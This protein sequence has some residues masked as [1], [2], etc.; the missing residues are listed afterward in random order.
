MRFFENNYKSDSSDED[1][2]ETENYFQKSDNLQNSTGDKRIAFL[3]KQY[4]KTGIDL[5]DR[6]K[7][8]EK[9]KEEKEVLYGFSSNQRVPKQTVLDLCQSQPEK[10]IL[11]KLDL[12]GVRNATCTPVNS[13]NGK[14]IKI[15]GRS[16]CGQAFNGDIVIVEADPLDEG[17]E[18]QVGRVIGIKLRRRYLDIEHPVFVCT[19]AE[20][21]GQLMIPL[22]KTVPKIHILNKRVTE[23]YPT[24]KNYKVE[25]YEYDEVQGY[26]RF[27]EFLEIKPEER[28]KY[29]YVVA[30]L[31]WDIHHHYPLGAVIGCF[32][33]KSGTGRLRALEMQHRIT[34]CYRQSTVTAVKS[35]LSNPPKKQPDSE[36]IKVYTIDHKN[37][38]VFDDGLSIENIS[39]GIAS[40]YKVGIHITDVSR[41]I[42]KDSP[43]DEEARERCNTCYLGKDANAYHML[44]EPLSTDLL[45]LRQGQPR[46][47][48]SIYTKLD[49][50]GRRSGDP[51]FSRSVI[52]PVKNLSYEEVQEIIMKG[53]A[54]TSEKS[55]TLCSL[56][57]LATSMRKLRLKGA[58][59]AFRNNP[60]ASSDQNKDIDVREAE[61][62]VEEFMILANT[63]VATKLME[64]FPSC[65][66]LR[67]HAHPDGRTTSTWLKKRKGICEAI[68]SLQ[69]KQ[70]RFSHPHILTLDNLRSI[71][72]RME[73]AVD[74]R[75]WKQVQEALEKKDYRRVQ[76]FLGS[77]VLHPKQSV[78]LREWIL[79]QNRA[80][81]CCSGTLDE[82]NR[83]HFGLGLDLYVKC[84]SPLRSYSDL[85]AQRMLVAAMEKEACPH[86]EEEI[87]EICL[88][89][90]D[91]SEEEKQY[92]EHYQ[93]LVVADF[94]QST[95][96]TKVPAIVSNLTQRKLVL[97]VPYFGTSEEY[98][99]LEFK[100]MGLCTQPKLEKLEEDDIVVAK[101]QKRIYDTHR[102]GFHSRKEHAHI[103][104]TIDPHR[105]SLFISSVDWAALLRAS[106][107][108]MANA[109]EKEQ[110]QLVFDRIEE[111]RSASNNVSEDSVT[112]EEENDD[113][114]DDDDDE[115]EDNEDEG[116]ENGDDLVY[117]TD[118]CSEVNDKGMILNH[119]C[120]FQRQFQVGQTLTVQMGTANRNGYLV[121]SVQMVFVTETVAYCLPH[122]ENP[123]ACLSEYITSPASQSYRRER[124]Y[125][126]TWIPIME[127]EAVTNIIRNEDSPLVKNVNVNFATDK[128]SSFTL[129]CAFCTE[130]DLNF[131]YRKLTRDGCEEADTE[132]EELVSDPPF[133]DIKSCD[134]LCIR[135]TS[136]TDSCDLVCHAKTTQVRKKKLRKL[137]VYEIC[138]A[139]HPRSKIPKKGTYDCSLEL[140]MKSRVDR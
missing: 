21:E 105:S 45:S 42:A 47:V 104:Y 58:H 49:G 73:I 124:N 117:A 25:L 103:L 41:M 133:Q 79:F 24:Q 111:K 123:I 37:T 67:C 135:C 128:P 77:D 80:R 121:P 127:M 83:K 102:I 32:E 44:P 6:F 134:F 26:L 115:E 69:D 76:V 138:F 9:Q 71:N 13:S 130:R 112:E 18:T 126:N 116:R 108:D 109:S 119:L 43:I 72:V 95:N 114:A 131:G 55:T 85:V 129:S 120:Q 78:A 101:W 15:K 99:S 35:I 27:K 75:I 137:P 93:T 89:S 87:E 62:L 94:L 122:M 3:N 34:S 52:K 97:T 22:C 51:F 5:S 20:M 16:N 11:C 36:T 54:D 110:L 23:H 30:Y 66:P 139:L 132:E 10:Y 57:D 82:E 107:K 63:M 106:M 48:I 46:H 113:K 140:L 91:A 28:E 19:A 60:L 68:M 84:T 100:L 33:T 29:V 96:A 17:E 59:Y 118:V 7:I 14:K 64:A 50:N 98:T 136:D 2:D 56:F 39:D 61:Y 125:V 90:N 92:M 65:I 74:I 12:N 86:T 4:L 81:Y 70:I 31:K 1:T 53:E 8:S 40:M 38:Q 88:D